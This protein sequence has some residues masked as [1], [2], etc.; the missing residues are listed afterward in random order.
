MYLLFGVDTNYFHSLFGPRNKLVFFRKIWY[1]K[2]KFVRRYQKGIY[3]I[4]KF[5]TQPDMYDNWNL[6]FY[7]FD[8]KFTV[9]AFFS[10]NEKF[11]YISVNDIKKINKPY[12]I[13]LNAV[14]VCSS[15]SFPHSLHLFW[16]RF[17]PSAFFQ[18]RCRLDASYK[19]HH[20]FFFIVEWRKWNVAKFMLTRT[21][22][23]L[24]HTTIDC[25]KFNSIFKCAFHYYFIQ[26]PTEDYTSIPWIRI[27]DIIMKFLSWIIKA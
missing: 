9:A 1:L 2:K 25:L 4:F 11:K 18:V 10:G 17:W 26:T 7:Y 13:Y 15:I 16:F 5:F 24:F 3:K 21:L 19:L 22:L 6:T 12:K 20:L 14:L 8:N 27:N 23:L